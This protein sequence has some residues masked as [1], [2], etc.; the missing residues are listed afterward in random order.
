MIAI[1]PVEEKRVG[2]LTA[3]RKNYRVKK[4]KKAGTKRRRK[5][6]VDQTSVMAAPDSI[7]MNRTIQEDSEPDD[8]LKISHSTPKPLKSKKNNTSDHFP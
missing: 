4:D 7:L 8:D 5:G 6:D 2:S 3:L 1:E